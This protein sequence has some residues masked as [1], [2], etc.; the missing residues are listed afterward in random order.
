VGE[1][2]CNAHSIT[3]SSILYTGATVTSSH[4]SFVT[5]VARYLPGA[6][7]LGPLRIYASN[8]NV[9]LLALLH[10]KTIQ[11]RVT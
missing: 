1:G 6:P 5:M 10:H 7:H 3:Y 2:D 9:F 4:Y 8:S 11:I